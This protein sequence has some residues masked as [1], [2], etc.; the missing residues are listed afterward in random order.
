LFG[1]FVGLG[2]FLALVV[3]FVMRRVLVAGE[4]VEEL[5]S[6]FEMYE[7]QVWFSVGCRDHV[8][9]TVHIPV[10][11]VRHLGLVN[12]ERV[13]VAVR[14]VGRVLCVPKVIY[15]SDSVCIDR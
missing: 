15:P 13:V 8:V 4:L 5:S 6:H 12:G 2:C 7:G 11:I 9:A 10:D 3:G 14:R 1:V